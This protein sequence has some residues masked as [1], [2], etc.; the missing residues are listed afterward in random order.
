MNILDPNREVRPEFVSYVVETKDD[1]EFDHRVDCCRV[2]VDGHITPRV[3]GKQDVEA[4]GPS[5]MQSQGQSLMPEGLEAGPG[6][7]D[8]AHLSNLD[9][10]GGG[11]TVERGREP[12]SRSDGVPGNGG[13]VWGSTAYIARAFGIT[14]G[15]EYG[16]TCA[17]F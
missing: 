13:Y 1:S 3:F 14:R 17:S 2:R 7:Q 12:W 9:P 10:D 5:K 15:L 16:K 8:L 11:E 4:A 6:P